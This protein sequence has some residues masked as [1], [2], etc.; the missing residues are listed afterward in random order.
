MARLD[1]HS[2]PRALRL[3]ACDRRALND[4]LQA[5][6]KFGK[7]TWSKDW[8]SERYHSL[9]IAGLVGR[10]F[11]AM[12]DTEAGPRC[13]VTRAGREALESA[14]AAAAIDDLNALQMDAAQGMRL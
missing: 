4:G 3:D 7:H 10:G 13:Y 1:N 2:L 12:A 11:M 5:L 6:K 14:Q 8:R 9:R